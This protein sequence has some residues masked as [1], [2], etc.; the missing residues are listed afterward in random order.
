MK[1]DI[2]EGIMALSLVRQWPL[3]EAAYEEIMT[4]DGNVLNNV[5]HS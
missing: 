3:R 1:T 5:S 2:R 4:S